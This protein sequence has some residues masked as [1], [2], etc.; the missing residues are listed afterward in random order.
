MKK[1]IY[2]VALSSLAVG[3]LDELD[4]GIG[5]ANRTQGIL[6][7]EGGIT[8]ELKNHSVV[9][10]RIDT[11][12]DL[13]IDSI[14]N[15]FTPVRDIN[16]DLVPYEENATVTVTD[17]NGTVF[18]FEEGSPGIYESRTPF[19]A[20]MDNSYQLNIVTDDG[21]GFSSEPMSVEGV[22][23]IADIY[24]EKTI[25]GTGAEGV[26]I[27][28]DNNSIS[29]NV[30][31]LRFTY[32]ETFKIIA[33]FWAEK[34]FL[35]TNYDP[36]ALPVP[37]Y[38]LEIVV[39]EQEEQVCYGNES[40]NTIIQ[41][42]QNNPESAGIEQFMV[43][44]IGR[45]NYILSHRYSIEVTQMVSGAASYGFYDQL[46]SFSE[47]GNV[48][49]QVQPGFLEGNLSADS[50][51]QGIVIGFFDVVSVS[52]R[53]LFFNYTDF[54]PNE[55][56]PPYVFNCN[57]ISSPETHRSFCAT[58]EGVNNCPQSVI[59]RVNLDLISYVRPNDGNI[60]VCPGPHVFVFRPCGDCT[61]LGSNEIPEFWIEE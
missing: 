11:L 21:R 14:F 9:L 19:A 20:E 58:G 45:E 16:R 29:G 28:I 22:S 56:L 49:S 42:E 26:G 4:I 23:E 25:S 46:N 3:C 44:F 34:D 47:T 24:A 53:R 55:P 37:T 36:C 54:Y 43:R 33:P 17:A 41:A 52:K 57:E 61:T 51:E 32:D 38:D 27:F 1:W 31:N 48:F 60:G 12:V 35:L 6:I 18:E 10:S 7:V 39:R 50:G 40:S 2:I 30:Q 15:P 5:S 8:N 59:E 13:G